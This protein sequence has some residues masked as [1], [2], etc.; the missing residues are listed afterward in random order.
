[1]QLMI[2]TGKCTECLDFES[3]MSCN[4]STQG[5]GQHEQCCAAAML[6]ESY[7]TCICNTAA[8]GTLDSMQLIGMQLAYLAVT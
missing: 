5:L 4:R 3:A 2:T 6:W 7:D 8:T 1:M